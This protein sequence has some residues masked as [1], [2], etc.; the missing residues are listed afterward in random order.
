MVLVH[1]KG[2]VLNWA[3]EDHVLTMYGTICDITEKVDHDAEIECL[4]TNQEAMINGTK[5]LLWSIDMDFK[6]ITANI[7]CIQLLNKIPA[8]P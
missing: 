8:T 4:K 1:E 2:K 7:P 6:L 3:P 5:D